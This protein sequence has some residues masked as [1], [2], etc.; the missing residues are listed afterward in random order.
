[1]KNL[2]VKLVE[3]SQEKDHLQGNDYIRV[4]VEIYG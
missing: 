2:E 3:V 1:M 4:S